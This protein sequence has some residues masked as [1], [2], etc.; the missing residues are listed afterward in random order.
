MTGVTFRRTMKPAEC[1]SCRGEKDR[2]VRSPRGQTVIGNI[3][4]DHLR[5]SAAGRDLLQLC[6]SEIANPAMVR[7]P[8][9]GFG[10][11]SPR[12]RMGRH[13]IQRS[14]PERRSRAGSGSGKHDGA[15]IRRY[16]QLR[17]VESDC[18]LTGKQCL[19][20]GEDAHSDHVSRCRRR[21]GMQDEE[22]CR[23]NADGGRDPRAAL[24]PRFAR[25]RANERNRRSTFR[26]PHQFAFHVAGV[27]PAF[28]R[29][30]L[31]TLLDDM[32]ERRRRQ[33]L[34]RGDR[35]RRVL[36]DRADDAGRRCTVERSFPVAIS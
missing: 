28:I 15:A 6:I 33:R 7:R 14:K 29:V 20:R 21:C 19:V 1:L 2:V 10:A 17:N 5:G 22:E 27:L 32:I 26:D 13:G 24:R 11:F 34:A 3:C 35:G 31:Q 25:A 9:R 18:I 4:N 36:Q 12:Q 16:S 30:P 23:Q 8:E